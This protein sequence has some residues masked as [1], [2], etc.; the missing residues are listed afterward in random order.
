MK[1]KIAGVL[2]GLAMLSVSA[3][4]PVL[5]MPA[6]LIPPVIDGKVN[7]EEWR[8]ALEITGLQLS[9]GQGLAKENT[10]IFLKYD[11]EHLYIAA[12]AADSNTKIL[13]RS[14]YDYDDCVEFFIMTPFNQNIY[15]WLFYS[16]GKATFNFVDSEYGGM[17]RSPVD[18][19]YKTTVNGDNWMLEAALPAAAYDLSGFFH[20][21]GWKVSC[22]RTFNHDMTSKEDGR[23]PEFSGFAP[24]LGQFQ[25]P[26]EFPDLRLKEHSGTPVKMRK[27]N[28]DGF[29]LTASAS[30][31][32]RMT[33][34]GNETT[35][36]SNR[37][38]VFSASI[39]K[40]IR[41]L[42]LLLTDGTDVLL[43]NRWN[44]PENSAPRYKALREKQMQVN[45]LGVSATGSF[46]RVFADLPYYGE[47]REIKLEAAR[48]E[49]ENF[50][51]VLFAGKEHV[52]NITLKVS[53]LR[54]AQGDEISAEAFRVYK[55]GVAH[56]LPVGYPTVRGAGDY[57]DPLYPVS[58]KME[59]NPGEVQP[60]WFS[61]KVPAN[62]IPG[63][64]NGTIDVTEKSGKAIRVAVQLEV[65][66]IT[67]P[68]K[69][70]LK[71]AFTVWETS[72]R[73]RFFPDEKTMDVEKFISL[74]DQY[75]EMLVEHRLSPLVFNVPSLL[76]MKVREAA[77]KFVM[78]PDGSCKIEAER[79]DAMNR[80]YLAAGATVFSTGPFLGHFSAKK[81]DI[82]KDAAAMLQAVN[83][84]YVENGMSK[85]A[86]LYPIDEPGNS[87]SDK[88]CMI[89]RLCR[90]NAPDLK[91]LVTGVNANFPSRRF[92]NIDYWVPALHWT[93]L[94]RKAEEQAA[95]REVWQYPCSGPWY[96]WPN[97]LLDTDAAAWRGVAWFTAKEKFDGILYWATAIYNYKTPF[98]NFANGVNGD[99][100]LQYPAEDG[101]P[102]ASIRLKVICDGM[103]DYE[104]IVQLKNAVAAAKRMRKD[105]AL[106]AEAEK[107]LTLDTVFRTLDDYSRNEADYRNFRRHAARLIAQL[108]D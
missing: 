100:V 84:H 68:K 49:F 99:G 43:K 56:A 81:Q 30:A 40:G 19:Q 96:P 103:E 62:A 18:I 32:L 97:Y 42:E 46:E 87:M 28:M 95:G 50:Q 92:D 6:T 48:N 104:Y 7:A 60:L 21:S 10:R 70:S 51:L 71:T 78:Q 82:S 106:I 102:L 36:V 12:I 4:S 86:F 66:P 9:T 47:S 74:V 52:K 34:N 26:L 44:F 2:F 20:S 45:G 54:N 3:E 65:F 93:N 57:P 83:K 17:L 59:L 55:E 88:V 73:R 75:A 63:T 5:T 14:K 77:Q 15:H 89:T 53:A 8:D 33:V 72:L 13:N 98:R 38:G 64:Y 22:H 105:P 76:P 91:I 79:Y 27:F 25:K 1:K 35:T 58:E 94:K 85:E 90:E 11:K 29:E 67:I 80:K 39:P 41:S 107:L 69:H 23:A 16:R 31:E 101:S 108:Q 37:N 24:I 61:L